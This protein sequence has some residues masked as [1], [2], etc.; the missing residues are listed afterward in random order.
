MDFIVGTTSTPF[1]LT[2]CQDDG[3]VPVVFNTCKIAL[4][5]GF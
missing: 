1:L 2:K 5:F 3:L 4:N